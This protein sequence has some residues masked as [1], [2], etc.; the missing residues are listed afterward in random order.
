MT[1]RRLLILAL[2][3]LPAPAAAQTETT[4]AD[5]LS[6]G[7]TGQPSVSSV[8]LVGLGTSGGTE[9]VFTDA[10]RDLIR[11]AIARSDL[12]TAIAYEDETNTFSLVQT[13]QATPVVTNA[14]PA[15]KVVETG[16]T[17]NRQR[18]LLEADAEEFEIQSLTD[19]DAV[20]ARPFR[21]QHAGSLILDP[22][23]K[24]VIPANQ[25]E[26][27]IG[28]PLQK[29][30]A[31]YA[32]EL[33]VETL[34]AQETMAT[35]GG[36]IL[37]GPTTTLLEDI[38]TAATTIKVK[39]NNLANGDRVV[40]EA[41]GRFEML[42]VT[43]AATR[44]NRCSSNC[45]IEAGA[46]GYFSDGTV[47]LAQ[48]AT[49]RWRGGNSLR[50]TYTSGTAN[51]YRNTAS[52][53]AN[54]TQ[55]TASVYVR[56]ADG[57]AVVPTGSAYQM[58]IDST[59]A[60]ITPSVQDVGDGWYRVYGTKTTSGA[61]NQVVGLTLIPT[62]TVHYFDA[63]QIEAG[64]TLTPWSETSSSYTV[65]RNLDTSGA[66][67]WE[68]GT[69]LFN[70]GTTGSG[71]IDAY[72]LRGL[73]SATEVGPTICGN[74][75]L[76]STYN[77]WAPRWCIGNLNGTY[78]YGATTFGFA[79]GDPSGSNVTV[80]PTNG[81][82][83]RNGVTNLMQAT[84]STLSLDSGGVVLDAD[85]V[86]ITPPTAYIT[87]KSFGFDNGNNP[88]PGLR[89]YH[90]AAI[91]SI[92]DMSVSNYTPL[93]LA[94]VLIDV[95]PVSGLAFDYAY[96]QIQ[97]DAGGSGAAM[98]VSKQFDLTGYNS[99]TGA[100]TGGLRFSVNGS[101]LNPGYP[102]MRTDGNYL[103]IN[104]D[105]T[106]ALYLNW[107]VSAEVY[108]GGNFRPGHV[109][110]RATNT[111][112]LGDTTA[113]WNEI[114]FNEPSTTTALFPLVSNSGRIMAKSDGTNGSFTIGGTCTLT[115]EYGILTGR[116]GAGCP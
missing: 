48:S 1:I 86:R 40:M 2:L 82:R 91:T 85:G 13:F 47:A 44:I 93:S 70:S 83:I 115:F 104:S 106:D 113:R 95:N 38:D 110:P 50:W 58:Y 55:Y 87:T 21:A 69:A 78:G 45:S 10:N 31:V 60:T 62:G 94:R 79:A 80:D 61:T 66:N 88:L 114:W 74:Q 97:S 105:G 15:W 112:S 25:Y 41:D 7:S 35:T 53:L 73:R 51:V 26:G 37:I 5:R 27:T 90:D 20:T 39:H 18:W 81:F 36:R 72:A 23:A 75:R 77:D 54:S 22:F 99:T 12:P 108:V 28:S 17:T 76:S 4:F 102:W 65:T 29:W 49:F 89:Y 107:D 19:A 52:E 101:T 46:T 103:V 32:A 30:L 11:R 33:N 42:A 116:S 24:Q 64:A 59:G 92:S 96:F 14:A 68:A 8:R 109:F 56:R 9:V 34:V 71:W 3:A 57:A 16:G 100:A 43:S 98:F 111:Y 84:G 6:V 63:W 67:V